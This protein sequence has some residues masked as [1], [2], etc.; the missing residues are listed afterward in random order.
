MSAAQEKK[1]FCIH[2]GK[3]VDLHASFCRNCGK[4]IGAKKKTPEKKAA[5]NDGIKAADSR[6]QPAAPRKRKKQVHAQQIVNVGAKAAAVARSLQTRPWKVVVGEPLPQNPFPELVKAAGAVGKK[7]SG[8]LGGPAF[9]LLIATIIEA[10][11]AVHAA[12]PTAMKGIYLKVV[13]ST[14]ILIFG[15]IAK[16]KKGFTSKLVMLTTLALSLI[17]ARTLLAGLGLALSHTSLFAS[18]L[19]NGIT[20]AIAFVAA[21]RIVK[22]AFIKG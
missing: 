4:N 2:C 19:P 9:F 16:D 7:L 13:L 21:L 11:A 5:S 18:Y 20:Q 17:Q 1:R 15:L 14:M 6:K 22:K 12:F 3:S 10:S 8:S